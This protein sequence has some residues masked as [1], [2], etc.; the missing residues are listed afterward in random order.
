V[1][2]A[3]RL[4]GH[5]AGALLTVFVDSAG[6]DLEPRFEP[7]PCP[8]EVEQPKRITCG[9][10]LVPERRSHSTRREVLL[11]VA[12][13]HPP[14]PVANAEPLLYPTGG[15]GFA[16]L[17]FNVPN[18]S[19]SRWSPTATSCSS[20]SA[21]PARHYRRSPAPRWTRPP[22]CRCRRETGR[23]PAQPA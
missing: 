16:S 23:P 21:G 7:G 14:A 17:V 11:A 3:K 20:T 1:S 22:S 2:R 6:A 13:I 4:L 19:A 8:A 10:L 18:S 15:P 12:V 5:V 9:R